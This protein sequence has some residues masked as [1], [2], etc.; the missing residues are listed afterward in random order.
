M[1]A[2]AHLLGVGDHHRGVLRQLVDEQAQLVDEHR[3]ERLHALDGMAVGDLRRRSRPARGASRPAPRP[4][5][6]PRGVS[7]SSR[8][9]GAQSPC[10]TSPRLRWSATL[11]ERTSSTAVAPPLDP[12]RVLLGRREDVEDAAAHGELAALLDQLHPGVGDVDQAPDDGVEPAVDVLA[13]RAA[14]PAPGR[15]DRA[16]AAAAGCGREPRR[17]RGGRWRGRRCWGA[18]S[19]RSTARRRPTV[20]A[21]GLSRSCGSVSQLGY[22]ATRSA[23]SRLDSAATRSSAS[24]PVAVT[25]STVR[26]RRTRPASTNGRRPV[27]PVRSTR[28][29]G[30]ASRERARATGSRET[31]SSRSRSDKGGPSMHADRPR[32]AGGRGV[33][34]ARRRVPGYVRTCR[35]ARPQPGPAAVRSRRHSPASVST[36]TGTAARRPVPPA[37]SGRSLLTARVADRSRS[38]TRGGPSRRCG[39]SRARRRQPPWR[40]R[41][42]R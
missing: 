17:R 28:R 41:S 42:H 38:A 18:R 36:D 19:R 9:G 37:A 10:P 2:R 16:P 13:L 22:R 4:A 8:Q 21:R 31:T 15:P 14:R 3:R 34:A 23:S 32:T 27:G 29:R 20:S 24:R 26:P 40:R 39:S 12:H 30:R 6:A 33:G 5:R 25:A 7:S 35:W 11:N 1:R